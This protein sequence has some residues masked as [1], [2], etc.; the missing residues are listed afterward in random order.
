MRVDVC[1]WLEQHDQA[2]AQCAVSSSSF[3]LAFGRAVVAVKASS[4]QSASNAGGLV[5]LG[6]QRTLLHLAILL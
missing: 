6:L 3:V 2:Q 1:S 4:C 5:M